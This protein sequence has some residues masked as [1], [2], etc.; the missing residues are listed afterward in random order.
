[1]FFLF[2]CAHSRL[3]RGVLPLSQ[4]YLDV[5][6][7]IA[8][9]Y[10][11]VNLYT[12]L[13]PGLVHPQTVLNNLSCSW[14]PRT[15]F[16][17]LWKLLSC[18]FLGILPLPPICEQLQHIRCNS[19]NGERSKGYIR[20]KGRISHSVQLKTGTPHSSESHGR[21]YFAVFPPCSWV[22]VTHAVWSFV[23]P[24]ICL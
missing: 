21:L 11:Q 18:I 20:K 4:P 22:R 19:E 9:T 1:M 23:V 14:T 2:T 5:C 17:P 24:S 13:L 8:S 12:S 6:N 10:F 3:L 7:L 16:L 15:V